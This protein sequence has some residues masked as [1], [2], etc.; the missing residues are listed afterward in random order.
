MT[1]RL[2]IYEKLDDVLSK[3]WETLEE[4]LAKTKNQPGVES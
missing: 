3:N 1:R 4:A 2:G